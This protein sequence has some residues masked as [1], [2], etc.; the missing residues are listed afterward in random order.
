MATVRTTT[1]GYTGHI[2]KDLFVEGV[3]E[4][5]DDNLDYYLRHGYVIEYHDASAPQSESTIVLP[6]A[7]AFKAEWVEVAEQ[8]GIAV[9]GLSL[10]KIKT[11]VHAALENPQEA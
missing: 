9:K 7:D 3:C 6:H 1:P 4:V 2:G 11:R 8:L 5:P 10:E